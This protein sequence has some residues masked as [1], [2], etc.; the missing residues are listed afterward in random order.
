MIR[1]PPRSTHCIS[2]AASDVYKRQL[3]EGNSLEFYIEGKR[4]RRGKLLQ[5]KVG[6]LKIL[7]EAYSEKRVEELYIVPTSIAYE[8]VLEAESFTQEFVGEGKVSESLGRVVKGASTLMHK[9]GTVHLS[10]GK[11]IKLSEY[12]EEG[13]AKDGLAN[14][15]RQVMYDISENMVVMATEVVASL[16]VVKKRLTLKELAADFNI[17]R[18]E[19]I[20]RNIK[21]VCV[22]ITIGVCARAV[23]G[24]H[25]QIMLEAPISRCGGEEHK[26]L[27]NLRQGTCQVPDAAGILPQRFGES[28]SLR[29]VRYVLAL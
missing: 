29:R 8:R 21:I 5:P 18:K 14:L 28:L 24:E 23:R 25:S 12:V 15:G 11:P 20:R 26:R 9:Y 3:M 7:V 27:L 19:L 13:K 2:S 22:E 17:V 16:V 1:R 6:L 10:F 4:S